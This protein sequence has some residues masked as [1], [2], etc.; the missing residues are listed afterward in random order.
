MKNKNQTFIC[1][2]V[3]CFIKLATYISLSLDIFHR[4]KY[5]HETTLNNIYIFVVSIDYFHVRTENGTACLALLNFIM[6]IDFS[7]DLLGLYCN[8]RC[9]CT[10]L[11]CINLN[12]ALEELRY[13]TL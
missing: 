13:C 4:Q 5:N 12:R 6:V 10:F 9:S 8:A 2:E 11:V 1:S 7:K 3:I